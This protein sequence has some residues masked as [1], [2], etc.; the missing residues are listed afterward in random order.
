MAAHERLEGAGADAHGGEQGQDAVADR[1]RAKDGQV[2]APL[3]APHPHL[4]RASI[5]SQSDLPAPARNRGLE[6][7]RRAR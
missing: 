1:V 2:R 5:S 4:E 6:Y 3:R 7:F